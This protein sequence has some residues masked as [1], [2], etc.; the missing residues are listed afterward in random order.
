MKQHINLPQFILR[1]FVEISLYF[2][3]TGLITAWLESTYAPFCSAIILIALSV[4][5]FLLCNH[6]II[7][8]IPTV[9]GFGVLYTE[10][11]FF[12]H[13]A[14]NLLWIFPVCVYQLAVTVKK[15]YYSDRD[16]FLKL[17]KFT[18]WIAPITG[19]I[20]SVLSSSLGGDNGGAYFAM[21]FLVSGMMLL[22]QTRHKNCTDL[23]F[24][25]MNLR[26]AGA[27]LLSTTVVVLAVRGAYDIICRIIAALSSGTDSNPLPFYEPEPTQPP[28]LGDPTNQGLREH[29][30]N[31]GKY[32]A[33]GDGSPYFFLALLILGVV[34]LSILIYRKSNGKSS[35]KELIRPVT[36]K[37]GLPDNKSSKQ[38]TTYSGN[39][40]IVRKCYKKFMLLCRRKHIDIHKSSTAHEICNAAK[41]IGFLP[42]ECEKLW[43]IY[44]LARYDTAP[45][46]REDAKSASEIY[47][48]I[49]AA[50]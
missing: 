19:I 4:V 2:S 13:Q 10:F 16:R 15:S 5:S 37:L 22:R 12:S 24:T 3:L 28:I 1:Q 50:L 14:I 8:F 31:N 32:E 38:R 34:I 49:K 7:R 44:T 20:A 17:Y 29:T 42:D 18:I 23:Y 26:A 27:V 41:E 25:G 47:T 48:R 36:E 6:K 30:E 33:V 11:A 35:I 43:R 45:V 21:I 39:R 46:S 9:L 40:G